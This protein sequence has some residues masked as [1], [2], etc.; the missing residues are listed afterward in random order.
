MIRNRYVRLISLF[1]TLLAQAQS[2]SPKVPAVDPPTP[3][4]TTTFRSELLGISF[5]FPKS[6]AIIPLDSLE[7]QHRFNDA[8]WMN[9]DP[10]CRGTVDQALHAIRDVP[11]PSN[12]SR[13]NLINRFGTE[14]RPDGN[15]ATRSQTD[16][17]GSLT[18]HRVGLVCIPP[19]YLERLEDT[20]AEQTIPGFPDAARTE[21]VMYLYR[22]V[23]HM[24]GKTRVHFLAAEISTG[25]GREQRRWVA[26]VQ[27]F[28]KD[29]LITMYLSS[30][31]HDFFNEMLRGDLTIGEQETAPLFPDGFDPSVMSSPWLLKRDIEGQLVKTDSP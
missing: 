18:I 21:H 10:E 30:N 23:G 25:D 29:C 5:T 6:L 17:R 19:D 8:A 14:D 20:Q 2:P 28:S 9:R 4:R 31:D 26:A 15:L 22:P 13:E 16:I 27:F 11:L 12:N 3:S 1:T 24:V 7:I